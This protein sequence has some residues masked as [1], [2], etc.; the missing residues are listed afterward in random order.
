MAKQREL[1]D[2]NRLTDPI[3]PGNVVFHHSVYRVARICGTRGSRYWQQEPD[4][5]DPIVEPC[6]CKWAP[7]LGEHYRVVGVLQGEPRKTVKR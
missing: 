4:G 3:E 1:A 2:M 5:D 7:E 6:P